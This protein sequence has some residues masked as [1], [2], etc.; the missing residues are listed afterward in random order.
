MPCSQQLAQKISYCSFKCLI[1]CETVISGS[2]P[3]GH[4]D[5]MHKNE[6][7]KNQ[8]STCINKRNTQYNKSQG[9]L[10]SLYPFITGN[11]GKAPAVWD[12]PLEA[13]I[14]YEPPAAAILP[15]ASYLYRT[16]AWKRIMSKY[17]HQKDDITLKL[18]SFTTCFSWLWSTSSI[19]KHSTHLW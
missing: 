18:F 4:L 13:E 5:H 19:M 12:K 7:L 6:H 17:L 2:V 15:F 9:T 3:S 16:P 10:P 8:C 1:C 11:N 14:T